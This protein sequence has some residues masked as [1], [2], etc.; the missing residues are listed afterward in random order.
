[1]NHQEQIVLLSEQNLSEAEKKKRQGLAQK[2][3]YVASKLSKISEN[4]E[5]G[6]ISPIIRI[7]KS[8]DLRKFELF[9]LC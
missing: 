3:P 5:K 9:P 2:N 1:M 4:E 7:E 6:I 8:F